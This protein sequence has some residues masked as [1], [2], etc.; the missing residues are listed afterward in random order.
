MGIAPPHLT[1][2]ISIIK[3]PRNQQLGALLALSSELL[4]A[5][6]ITNTI[7]INP[8]KRIFKLIGLFLSFEAQ[9]TPG[10]LDDGNI[11]SLGIIN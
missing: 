10:K 7:T 8:M 1:I 4:I 9:D 2:R 3:L 5:S 11:C 6:H